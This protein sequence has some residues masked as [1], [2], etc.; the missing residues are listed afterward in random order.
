MSKKSDRETRKLW[1]S[2]VADV[3]LVV[4]SVETQRKE[5]VAKADGNDKESIL[6]FACNMPRRGAGLRLTVVLSM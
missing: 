4:L 3:A 2:P 6:V 5:D 1:T